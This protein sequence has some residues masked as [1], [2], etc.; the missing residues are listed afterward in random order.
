[1]KGSLFISQIICKSL[2]QNIAASKE[3]QRQESFTSKSL[4]GSPCFFQVLVLC[5]HSE[6]MARGTLSEINPCPQA[7]QKNK[8]MKTGKA[9]SREGFCA[10]GA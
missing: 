9:A 7:L 5:K 4:K 2:I 1:M 3:N 10:R 6:G 8:N